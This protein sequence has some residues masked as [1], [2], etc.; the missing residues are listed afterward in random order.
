MTK[1]AEQN[2]IDWAAERLLPEGETFDDQK[3]AI[4]E[5]N[6]GRDIQACPGSGKTTTLLVKLAILSRKM[7]FAD[8]KGICV[9]THTNV[10]IDEIKAKLGRESDILFS[11]PNFFGTI[12]SFVDKFFTIPYFNSTQS[13]N[14]RDINDDKAYGCMLRAY[15]G[16]GFD[17]VKCLYGRY[18]E[19]IDNIQARNASVKFKIT[20]EIYW[21][22]FLKEAYYDATSDCYFPEYRKSTGKIKKS[23]KPTRKLLDDVKGAGIKEGVLTYE[24]AFS[25][26]LANAN[27]MKTPISETVSKRFKYLFMDE[28]Q[29]TSQIQIDF[30]DEIFDKSKIIVQRFGDP[31]QAIFSKEDNS[32]PT[33]W[34][35]ENPLRISR[36]KR[37]GANIAEVLKTVCAADNHDLEGNDAVASLKPVMIVFLD[38][39]KV[40][41]KFIDIVKEKEVDGITIANMA[42]EKKRED[43]LHRNF[44]K[45][46]G[47]V[48]SNDKDNNLGITDY[49]PEFSKETSIGRHDEDDRLECYILRNDKFSVKQYEDRFLEVFLTILRL[50]N[51]R[52]TETNRYYTKTSLIENLKKHNEWD[53]LRLKM[54]NWIEEIKKDKDLV[55]EPVYQSIMEYI[56]QT[57]IVEFGIVEKNQSTNDFITRRSISI[58]ALLDDIGPDPGSLFSKDGIEVEVGTIHSVKGETHIATLHMETTYRAGFDSLRIKDQLKGNVPVVRQPVELQTLKMAYVAM[59]RPKYLL[60]MAVRKDHFDQF[61]GPELRSRWDIVTT[62]N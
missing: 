42:I 37:F 59:S 22:R 34:K 60:C 2:E 39:K 23:E 35:I 3:M 8:G 17:D 20:K 25:F 6:E 47:W 36:S 56:N 19:E 14:I 33:P 9:L 49:F 44:I 7:P 11:Y 61:D 32:T 30:L 53:G 28:M 58:N 24:N 5:C 40:I 12:Q 45:A 48:K 31:Y 26:A 21:D 55:S 38:A 18:K 51:V 29:D 50:E 10:A 16:K 43:S 54:I 62:N 41:P 52:V 46:V 4:I 15:R 1:F 57:I 13:V 27:L